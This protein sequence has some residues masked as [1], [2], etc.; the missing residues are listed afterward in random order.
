[1][2]SYQMHDTL[3]DKLFLQYFLGWMCHF[4][5]L[6]WHDSLKKN[7]YDPFSLNSERLFFWATILGN[8]PYLGQV[9]EITLQLKKMHMI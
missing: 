3:N 7:M 6:F 9:Y 5:E 8:F 2:I 4:G 1:M